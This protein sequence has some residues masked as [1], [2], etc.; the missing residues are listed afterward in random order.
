MRPD[1][2]QLAQCVKVYLPQPGGRYGITFT[3]ERDP[4]GSLRLALVA[5]GL[6]HPPPGSRQPSV[7][8][9]AYRRLHR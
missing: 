8:R 6:R 2:M 3:I 7:Y 5:F 9:I 1:G 4:R